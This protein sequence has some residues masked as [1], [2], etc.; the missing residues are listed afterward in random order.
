MLPRVN[1][2]HHHSWRSC[3]QNVTWTRMSW[4]LAC[5]RRS[6]AALVLSAHHALACN[7]QLSCSLESTASQQMQCML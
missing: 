1:Y 2:L 3:A 5:N 7:P 6:V 4:T